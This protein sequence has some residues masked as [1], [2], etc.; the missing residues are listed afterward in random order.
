LLSKVLD[1]VDASGMPFVKPLAFTPKALPM[2]LEGPV[3]QMKILTTD[4]EKKVRRWWGGGMH[5]IPLA[6]DPS[7]A[8]TILITT[9]TVLYSLSQHCSL[10]LLLFNVFTLFLERS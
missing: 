6:T 1:E 10:N 9:F 4:E 5:P 2:F 8:S 7:S 3:R